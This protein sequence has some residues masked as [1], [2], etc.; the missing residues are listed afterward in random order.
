MKAYALMNLPSTTFQWMIQLDPPVPRQGSID[1]I[2][3]QICISHDLCAPWGL[4]FLGMHGCGH[5]YLDTC[6]PFVLHS[7]VFIFSIAQEH[8]WVVHLTCSPNRGLGTPSSVPAFKPPC[9]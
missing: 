8:P 6:L 2:R 9:L 4:D 1:L 3:S 5:Y 7:A